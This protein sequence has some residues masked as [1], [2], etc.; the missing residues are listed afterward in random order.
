MDVVREEVRAIGG[1]IE[2]ESSQGEGV[3]FTIRLPLTTAA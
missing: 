3:T 1:R 2:V